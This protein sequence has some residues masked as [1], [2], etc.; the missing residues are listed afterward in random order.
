M[1]WHGRELDLLELL[2]R[3]LE[4]AARLYEAYSRAFPELEEFW[5]GLAMEEVDS[6][7]L[8][9]SCIMQ[10]RSGSIHVDTSRID[11]AELQNLLDSIQ[12]ELARVQRKKIDIN[13]AID[14]AL[15]IERMIVEGEYLEVLSTYLEE[16]GHPLPYPVV[17]AK[18]HVKV[19]EQMSRDLKDD[20]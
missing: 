12:G 14:S 11:E 3:T 17:T 13:D 15:N 19:L 4:N 8:V 9:H 20:V 7:N 5:F 10:I 2:A 6:S 18:N 1:T 16:I